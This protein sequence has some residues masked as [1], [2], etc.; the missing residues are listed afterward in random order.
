[1]IENAKIKAVKMDADYFPKMGDKIVNK[2]GECNLISP[3]VEG[4]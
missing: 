1:M 2:C 4:K 3:R